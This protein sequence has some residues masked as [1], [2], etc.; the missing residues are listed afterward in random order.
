VYQNREVVPL[1]A[2]GLDTVDE[3]RHEIETDTT[4]DGNKEVSSGIK[5]RVSYTIC[6]AF[7]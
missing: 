3:I 5:W 2:Y 6:L 1:V 7:I 4:D